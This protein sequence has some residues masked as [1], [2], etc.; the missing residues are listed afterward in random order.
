[1]TRN[2]L[3]GPSAPAALGRAA[4]LALALAA[5]AAAAPLRA[6]EH[7]YDR[8]AIGGGDMADAGTTALALSQAGLV[9]TNP[10]LAGFGPAAPLAALGLKYGIKHALVASGRT[11]ARAEVTVGAAGYGAAC[12]N[13]MT[14][15]GAA[16]PVAVVGL[17]GCHLVAHRQMA[18][19]YERATGHSIDGYSTAAGAAHGRLTVRPLI[20]VTPATG[21]SPAVVQR[22][23]E[24]AAAPAVRMSTRSADA[25]APR[26]A[27]PPV[28][29]AGTD[30]VTIVVP[31][32]GDTA[33]RPQII[34]PAPRSRG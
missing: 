21:D 24:A 6:E 25:P 34:V 29:A 30:R 8:V 22:A 20:L 32:P 7:R 16:L 10:M 4:T 23:T 5:I 28:P 27:A 1:M 12:A 9:E 17:V 19:S 13:L 14:V 18:R 26:R 15:A 33:A 2:M 3:N 11:P 31:A